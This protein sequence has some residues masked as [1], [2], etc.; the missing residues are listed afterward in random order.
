MKSDARLVKDQ[1]VRPGV[2]RFCGCSHF[3]P[4]PEG[5][6]WADRAETLCSACTDIDKAWRTLHRQ[7]GVRGDER[8][9]RAFTRGFRDAEWETEAKPIENPYV[10]GFRAR[11]WRFGYGAGRQSLRPS[12]PARARR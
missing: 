3:N 9:R 8:G 6:W 11:Y 4:C 5:C 7:P 10:G 12:V 2:C 1:Q